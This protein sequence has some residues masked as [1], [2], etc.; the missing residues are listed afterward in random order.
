MAKSHNT[1]HCNVN[2]ITDRFY[3][4]HKPNLAHL[5]AH[6]YFDEFRS[7]KSA[8]A[9]MSFIFCDTQSG[10]IIDIIKSRLLHVLKAYFLRYTKQA[11]AGL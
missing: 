6:L 3:A 4:Y 7:V 11:R 9:A 2:R 8:A 1:S 10:Q 5:P